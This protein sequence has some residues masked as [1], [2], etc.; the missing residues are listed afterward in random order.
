[1]LCTQKNI[2]L[3]QVDISTA[4]SNGSIPEIWLFQTQKFLF[5]W[6]FE[7]FMHHCVDCTVLVV[8]VL[9]ELTRNYGTLRYM[10]ITDGY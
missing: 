7:K 3:C 6:A 9:E 2:A 5:W 8:T 10:C 1:M 4:D